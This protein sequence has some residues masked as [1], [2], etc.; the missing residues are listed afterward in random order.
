M[1]EEAD[2]FAVNAE[3]NIQEIEISP[4]KGD[5]K[6]NDN[7]VLVRFNFVYVF[8]SHD[9]PNTNT[10]EVFIDNKLVLKDQLID[11]TGGHMPFDRKIKIEK[12]KH[13]LEI[14]YKETKASNKVEQEFSKDT[15]FKV[16]S[17]GNNY[18]NLKLEEFPFNKVFGI[19]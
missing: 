16:T 8:L 6:M 15:G 11:N 10:Y 19:D 3:G 2:N 4:K 17:Y 9:T 12:G 1:T 14:R 7:T 5:S 13:L 18:K